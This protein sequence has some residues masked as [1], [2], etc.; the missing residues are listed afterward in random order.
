MDIE[1]VYCK[2][3]Y[4]NKSNRSVLLVVIVALMQLESQMEDE[5]T[6]QYDKKYIELTGSFLVSPG[7]KSISFKIISAVCWALVIVDIIILSHFT[8]SSRKRL[9]AY[10]ACT[11]P[12]TEMRVDDKSVTLFSEIFSFYM[13][14]VI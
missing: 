14:T 10:F 2:V 13:L 12:L 3:E 1:I 7:S 9:P 4:K 11:Q 5:R 6:D 8:P